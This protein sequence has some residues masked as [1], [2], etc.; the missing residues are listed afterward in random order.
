MS[1][2]GFIIDS[3]PIIN[4]IQK[5]NKI[6]NLNTVHDNAKR[7]SNPNGELRYTVKSDTQSDSSLNMHNS[8]TT[9]I[10]LL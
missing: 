1:N 6:A 4:Q 10:T 8:Q 3:C 9:Y 5:V 2:F 7:W